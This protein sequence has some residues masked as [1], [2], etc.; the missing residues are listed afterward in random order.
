MLSI[1]IIPL[2]FLAV[3]V[4]AFVQTSIGFGLAI[5][6]SPLLFYLDP[7]FVPAP[8]TIAAL[9]NSLFG[10]WHFRKHLSLRGLLAAAVAR[11]PGSLVGAGLLLLVSVQ[12]LAVLIALVIVVGMVANFTRV[13]IPY[14]RVS[15]AIAGFL[16]GVMGTA[17]AI[18]G[19][20][21]AIVMQG[22][23]AN[24]IRG[25]LAAFFI[26]S[27]VISLIILTLIGYVGRQQLVLAMPL[28]PAAWLGGW[29]ASRLS[30]R[31]N[32]RW[33]TLATIVLCG[34]SVIVMLSQ[35]L[36]K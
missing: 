6:S 17:T 32:E 28:I 23:Q 10:S 36:A 22:Q 15:L 1:E 13:N 21:M 18:G 14:N 24:A 25:N 33:I 11:V 3:F 30:G 4:G 27:C 19:P 35:Y 31:I 9:T 34:F 5:V 26:F 7:L 16:S 29:V 2:A 8:I 20:P 12:S